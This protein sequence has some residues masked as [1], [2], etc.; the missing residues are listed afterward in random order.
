[1]LWVDETEDRKELREE[2]D[3]SSGLL[4]ASGVRWQAQRNNISITALKF[5]FVFITPRTSWL[6]IIPMKRPC[7]Y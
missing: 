2:K 1:M 4:E 7:N 3:K 5:F 6:E